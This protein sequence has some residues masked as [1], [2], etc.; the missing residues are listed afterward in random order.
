MKKLK[1]IT[2]L[3]LALILVSAMTSCTKKQE[4]Q[5]IHKIGAHGRNGGKTPKRVWYTSS[6]KTISCS[7]ASCSPPC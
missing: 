4:E 2:V 6:E 7:T 5:H 1:K 3:L